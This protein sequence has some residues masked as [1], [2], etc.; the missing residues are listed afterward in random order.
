M[1]II[2][3]IVVVVAAM[4]DRRNGKD[5]KKDAKMQYVL[6]YMRQM[7]TNESENNNFT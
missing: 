1:L 7:A 3:R 6:V 5:R 2:E 4:F